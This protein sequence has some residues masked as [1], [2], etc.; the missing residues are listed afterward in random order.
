MESKMKLIEVQK[1]LVIEVDRDL[2]I[3]WRDGVK[4]IAADD[5]LTV[6]NFIINL[7]L[8]INESREW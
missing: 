2:L 3:K 7:D 8:M 5:D 1:K 4:E 6:Q